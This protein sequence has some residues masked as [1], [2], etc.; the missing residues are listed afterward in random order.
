MKKTLGK[1]ELDF[2]I[3]ICK[4]VIECQGAQHFKPVKFGGRDDKKS[5]ESFL[6]T[7]ELDSRKKEKYVTN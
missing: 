6:H 3:P 1:Q 7:I 2:F 4:L 5:Y